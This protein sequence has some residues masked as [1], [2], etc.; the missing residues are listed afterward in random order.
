MRNINEGGSARTC[1]R[2]LEEGEMSRNRNAL[3]WGG[4]LILLGVAFLLESF[5]IFRFAA[6]L[7]WTLVLVGIGLPFWFVYLSDRTRWW[8]LFPGSVMTGIGLGVLVGGSLAGVLITAS[9][10]LPFWLVYF[11]DRRHWW[12]LIPGWT[13]LAVSAIVLLGWL[14]LD[15]FIGP[16]FMFAIAAPFLVVYVLDRDQWWALIPGGIMAVIGMAWLVAEL[17]KGFAFWPVALIALGIWLIYRSYVPRSHGA[18]TDVGES[19]FE[20]RF[21]DPEP[22]DADVEPKVPR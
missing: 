7:V 19:A 22:T 1:V 2:A 4:L 11:T 9:I 5:D 6:R 3:A 15:W 21:E 13:M 8:S 12:A 16:F 10:S 14:G 17:M 18:D 20:S